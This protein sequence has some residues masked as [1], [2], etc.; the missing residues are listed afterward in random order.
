VLVRLG[1][2]ASHVAW[3]TLT[4][5][6]PELEYLLYASCTFARSVREAAVIGS[7]LCCSVLRALVTHFGNGNRGEV[8]SPQIFIF[9]VEMV[10]DC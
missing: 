2:D 7:I 4:S 3:T 10:D 8:A 5:S 6:E 9:D 1:E